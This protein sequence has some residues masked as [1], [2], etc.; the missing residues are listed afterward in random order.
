[1]VVWSDHRNGNW[2]IYQ[3]E[4]MG[5][6]EVQRTY[7]PHN[8]D[9]VCMYGGYIA[10]RD[11][12]NG[13]YDIYMHDPA[14]GANKQVTTSSGNQSS[15]CM[16]GPWIVWE[17]D[18][19]GNYDLYLYDINSEIEVQLTTA[20][21]NQVSPSIFGDTVVYLDDSDGDYEVHMG[22]IP[23]LFADPGEVTGLPG[24]DVDLPDEVTPI[25]I[26]SRKLTDDAVDQGR[27]CIWGLDI[28]WSAA[29]AGNEDVYKYSVIS[30][31]ETKL[32]SDPHDQE[33]P[34]IYANTV[35]WVDLRNG[36][37]DIYSYDTITQVSSK[38][39]VTNADERSP[40]IFDDRIVWESTGSGDGGIFYKVLDE[41]SEPVPDRLRV[42]IPVSGTDGDDTTG[43]IALVVVVTVVIIVILV[44]WNRIRKRPAKSR[45]P[46]YIPTMQE[47]NRLKTKGDYIKLCNKLGL[48]IDGNKKR[49]RKRLVAYVQMHQMERREKLAME[50]ER[51]RGREEESMRVGESGS[52]A[53]KVGLGMM[54]RSS[55]ADTADDWVVPSN[56]DYGSVPLEWDDGWFST[57]MIGLNDLLELGIIQA[58]DRAYEEAISEPVEVFEAPTPAPAPKRVKPLRRT[59]PDKERLDLDWDDGMDAIGMMR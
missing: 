34:V 21:S 1:M 7:D 58:F 11:D 51:E 49:L 24:K 52:L 12:R 14:T 54:R 40:A 10:W 55:D 38:L 25:M 16:Y 33:D 50:E 15:P 47:I 3:Y 17:D 20:A 57:N 37:E 29:R 46:E 41:D 43:T 59:G 31:E 4:L 36:N 22:V 19:N 30:N 45:T 13:D 32:T 28:V 18:R 5:E 39:A 35:L 6:R 9:Q 23:P 56:L 26:E 44:S 27:P 53:R 8:Q 48:P 2:D 42:D